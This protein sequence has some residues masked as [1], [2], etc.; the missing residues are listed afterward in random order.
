MDDRD[1][2]S[3]PDLDDSRTPADRAADSESP[4]SPLV[5]DGI[6]LSSLS[7]AGIT[8]RRVGWVAAGLISAWIVVIFARQ[9]GEAASA[10]NRADQIASDNAALAAEVA[11]LEGELQ[12]VE[13][14]EYIAQQARNYDLGGSKEIPFT[15]DSSVPA[16]GP[17]APGSASTRVGVRD[18]RV[19][20]LESWL[21]L[22]FGPTD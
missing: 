13:R 15:L 20:P 6:D 12:M 5:A 1:S 17:N 4:V 3:P 22:L 19:S 2:P 16:P 11:A 9:A 8:R 18:D 10:A 21:S 7:I 14:P